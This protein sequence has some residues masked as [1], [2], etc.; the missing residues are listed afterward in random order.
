L[1]EQGTIPAWVAGWTPVGLY[2]L[3]AGVLLALSW[4]R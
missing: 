4:R 1:G 2:A 3:A